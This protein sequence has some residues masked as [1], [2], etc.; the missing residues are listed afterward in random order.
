[1]KSGHSWLVCPRPNPS[2]RR[3]LICAP[4]AGAGPAVFREWVTRDGNVEVSVV[5]LPGR[6][7]REGREG[8]ESIA[9]VADRVAEAVATDDRPFALFGCSLGA[10]V[11]FEVARRARPTSLHV[12]S[13][14][15]PRLPDPHRRV[16]DLPSD[17]FIV[18]VQRRYG[19]AIPAPV[20][21]D[22]ELRAL[23]IPV[24]QADIALIE[25][26][27]HVPSEPLRCPVA[28]YG[29]V[30]DPNATRADLDAWAGETVGP[31]TVRQF[32]GGHFFLQTQRDAL[33]RAIEQDGAGAD[34]PLP[35]PP[36]QGAA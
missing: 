36:A 30:D 19:N 21:D 1:V 32:P 3:R 11:A 8:C 20:L 25:D 16:S 24:L 18:E 5:Q 22:P 7:P 28:A 27:T 33:L 6:N 14:R 10:L 15:A 35:S 2:A 13:R 31:F 34:H 12:A 17:A 9:V 4:Y 29:G 23:L 26:Y